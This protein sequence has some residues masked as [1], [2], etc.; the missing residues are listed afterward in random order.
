MSG[1][2]PVN[3]L[4]GDTSEKE[5]PYLE[6]YLC[7]YGSVAVLCPVWAQ[8]PFSKRGQ[9]G[10][11][12]YRSH[13]N[14]SISVLKKRIKCTSLLAK[15]TLGLIWRIKDD[16]LKLRGQTSEQNAKEKFSLPSMLIQYP[17]SITF[18]PRKEKSLS[19]WQQHTHCGRMCEK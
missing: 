11:M 5:A 10:E 6:S 19:E 8:I 13:F 17:G 1:T 16:E 4:K 2:Y 3:Q 12:D 18:T 14:A 7:L 9:E 15:L